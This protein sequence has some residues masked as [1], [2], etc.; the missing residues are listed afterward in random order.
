MVAILTLSLPFKKKGASYH[1]LHIFY[2]CH[3]QDDRFLRWLYLPVEGPKDSASGVFTTRYY[4]SLHVEDEKSSIESYRQNGKKWRA[5]PSLLAWNWAGDSCCWRGAGT[6]SLGRT[7]PQTASYANRI[8]IHQPKWIL[9]VHFFPNRNSPA[10]MRDRF[11]ESCFIT[12]FQN[13]MYT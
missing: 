5:R 1:F 3:F 7:S 2:S 6:S 13:T 9:S 4:V 11:L 8:G 12:G 10:G